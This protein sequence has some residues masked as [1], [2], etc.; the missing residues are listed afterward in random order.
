MSNFRDKYK[1]QKQDLLRRHDESVKDKGEG[2][3]GS[4]LDISKMPKGM[5]FWKC[6]EDRHTI[7]I[8]PFIA[9]NNMP[10]VSGTTTDGRIK[11]GQFA[12][13]VDVYVHW[14]VGV[15]KHPY[16]CPA[17]T[18]GQPCPICEYLQ[19]HR[20]EMTKAEYDNAKAKR[21]T[22]YLVWCHDNS[23]EE[24][25]GIQVWEVA[26]YFMEYNLKEISERPRGG[27]TIPFFDP[28]EGKNIIFTKRGKGAGNV[29]FIGHRFD[30]RPEPIPESILDKSFSLD[31]AMR[32]SSYAELH[33]AF[34]G[35]EMDEDSGNEM[36]PV[37]EVQERDPDTPFDDGPIEDSGGEEEL[38]ADECPVGG[39]FAVDFDQLE[40][41]SGCPNYDNCYAE[42]QTMQPEPEPEPEPPKRTPLRRKP[43][44]TPV[45]AEPPARKP[46]PSLRRKV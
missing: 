10:K 33:T 22:F 37:G 12:Y 13:V 34:Y 30:E 5:N 16:I 21:R 2:R 28:D 32:Y 4:I 25:K 42:N 14:N 3:F 9:G 7:D 24:G 8:I 6:S 26:H 31:E 27:G 18:N 41:C 11:E 35:E 17:H 40:N 1:K 15:L 36:T 38:A 19:A 20:D 46:K 39:E 43:A 23:A 29:E 45:E 44:E